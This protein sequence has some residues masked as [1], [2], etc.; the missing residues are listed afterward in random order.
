MSHITSGVKIIEGIK[1]PS[2]ITGL[3][4]EA[5]HPPVFHSAPK[6]IFRV[7]FNRLVAQVKKI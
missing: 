6:E 3:R 7:L 1:E 5:E 4:L 2:D